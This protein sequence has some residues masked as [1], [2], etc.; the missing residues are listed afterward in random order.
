MTVFL[1]KQTSV[2]PS[3][4]GPDPWSANRQP[5]DR[6]SRQCRRTW[7]RVTISE[8]QLQIYTSV[9]PS[10]LVAGARFCPN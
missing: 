2:M 3:K 5:M 7:A 4:I 1:N 9:G 8:K 6:R 10:A